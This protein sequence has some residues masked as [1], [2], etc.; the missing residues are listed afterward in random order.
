[1][2]LAKEALRKQ[3]KTFEGELVGSIQEKE[4]QFRYTWVRGKARFEND[5]RLQHKTYRTGLLPYLLHSRVLVV[6]TAPLIYMVFFPFALLDIFVS[7]YQTVCFPVYGIPKVKRA[8]HIVFDRGHLAYLNL[9]ERLNC[10]YCSYANGVCSY[11]REIAGRTEQHWC[12]IK[13]A[14][15]LHSPHS[16]YQHFVDYGDAS[17]YRRDLETVRQDFSD[18][19]PKSAGCSSRQA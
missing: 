6:L 16:R 19:P 3:I 8:D 10:I 5:I 18:V 11:A 13:H 7:I 15:R 9:L 2:T 1:M 12:P 4:R 14:Q 17:T